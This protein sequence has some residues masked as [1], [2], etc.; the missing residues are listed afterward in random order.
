MYDFKIASPSSKVCVDIYLEDGRLAYS[1]A[2]EGKLA[3]SRSPLG[4]KAAGCDFTNGLAFIK[5]EE[6]SINETYVIP[7]FKKSE[8]L[9]RCNAFE[10]F[11]E[12]EGK[13]LKVEARSYD[14]GGAV[15]LTILGEGATII[16]KETTGFSV[17]ASASNIY[18]QKQLF[19]YEDQYSSVPKEDLF[20]NTL[21]F[22]ILLQIGPAHYALYCEAPIY[23]GCYW[24]SALLAGKE[25]KAL[26]NVVKPVDQLDPFETSL[27][28][29]TPWRVALTGRLNDIVAS[30]LLENLNPPPIAEDMSFVLPGKAAWSWMTENNSPSNSKRQKEYIDYASEMGFEYSLIDADWPGNI[31]VKEMVSYGASKNVKVWIWEH[32]K[33][34]LNAE[35]AQRSMKLWASWGVAGIKV[36]FFESDSSET[37]LHYKMIA[38]VAARNRLMLNFHGCSKPTGTSRVWPHVL[39]FEAVMGGEYFQH[40][41]NFLP[42]GP[43]AAH[44][45][46]LP[47]TRNAVGPMDYTPVIFSTYNTA[48]SDAHQCAL[49]IIFTSYILHVGEKAEIVINHSCKNFL[50]R[51]P[52]SWDETYLIEGY[53]GSHATIARRKAREWFIAG[54][55]AKKPRNA[56]I[57][58][59][60]IECGSYEA[61]L[62]SDDLEDELPFDAAEGALPHATDELMSRLKNEMGRNTLHSHNMHEVQ[63]EAFQVNSGESLIIPMCANG[64]FAMRIFPTL[65][66]TAYI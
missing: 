29:S 50:K 12:K 16:D 39:S 36:D 53:P 25:D 37:I 63:I 38:E 15:R 47:F 3:V 40:Y 10:L 7:A 20:Q 65:S 1:I 33:N 26:L 17:P 4:I 13:T 58:L 21:A 61:E 22:P 55:C 62:C 49:P 42:M 43:D 27:P 6:F 54:I 28:F 11:L 48:T 24:G 32:S 64:G 34:F 30:N 56:K 45:C 31:D 18:A 66:N 60:F 57:T 14:D 51:I 19:S 35:D 44:N 41:S 46:M 5:A 59:D 9:N 52:A 2:S 23:S 8:C